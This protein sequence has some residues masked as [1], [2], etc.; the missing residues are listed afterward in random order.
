MDDHLFLTWKVCVHD[1]RSIWWL[2]IVY[3]HSYHL[4]IQYLSKES[5][6]LH[7]EFARGIFVNDSLVFCCMYMFL[8]ILNKVINNNKMREWFHLNRCILICDQSMAHRRRPIGPQLDQTSPNSLRTVFTHT[9]LAW[10]LIHGTGASQF[11][12]YT[13]QFV[14]F[15]SIMII[16]IC[17]PPDFY[18]PKVKCG[19]LNVW[20]LLKHFDQK[21]K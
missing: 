10:L 14:V 12:S 19:C 3:S 11:V 16:V 13:C 5:G 15:F 2:V 8:W 4:F 20:I 1:F 9:F 21:D 17:G 6:I 7:M 18:S